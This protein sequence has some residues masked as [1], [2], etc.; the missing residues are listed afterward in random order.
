LKVIF[1]PEAE[2][3]LSAAV[4]FVGSRNVAAGERMYRNI[5]DLVAR[6][7]EGEFEGPENRLHSGA[8]VRSW[9]ISPY[10]IYYQRGEDALQI[11]RIYH[12]ARRPLT[13]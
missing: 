2:R 12:Q 1:A 3:D 4:E 6:L 13:G 10:R 5:T 7:A 8:T 9:P 11:V